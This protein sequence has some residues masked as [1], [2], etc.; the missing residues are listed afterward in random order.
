MSPLEI[1][2]TAVLGTLIIFV[3][4]YTFFIHLNRNFKLGYFDSINKTPIKGQIVF[5]GD[6]LTDF[7]PVHEFFPNKVIY[8]RG[9]AADTTDQLLARIQN[10]IELQPKTIFLQIGTNDLGKGKN[11]TFIVGN[12]MKIVHRLKAEIPNVKIYVISLYPISRRRKTLSFVSCLL[13]TNHN[14]VICNQLLKTACEKESLDFIN[15]HPLLVDKDGRFANELTLE[16]LHLSGKG[17]EVIA[18]ALRQ[19][20]Q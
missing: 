9:I 2:L 6:S 14:I 19:Y 15:L 12:I 11:P 17:Y 1:V 3:V 7:F 16:G 8:N 10:V 5:F 4:F 13:R 18:N 20:V